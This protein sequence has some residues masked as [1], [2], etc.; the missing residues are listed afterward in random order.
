M[1][2]KAKSLAAASLGALPVL[3]LPLLAQLAT[4]AQSLWGAAALSG[5]LAAFGPRSMLIKALEIVAAAAL[6]SLAL[7]NVGA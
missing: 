3:A 7:V 6:C 2:V 5:A 4:A 1:A